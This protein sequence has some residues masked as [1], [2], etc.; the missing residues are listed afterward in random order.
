MVLGSQREG[1][2]CCTSGF[3]PDAYVPVVLTLSCPRQ[4]ARD[5]GLS[6]QGA[7]VVQ[8]RS[9][10][11]SRP[12]PLERGDGLLLSVDD[13]TI[14]HAQIPISPSGTSTSSPNLEIT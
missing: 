2:Q 1:L 8:C 9:V 7:G 10:D 12:R 3:S 5:S 6:T 14:A 13:G 11:G 4:Q